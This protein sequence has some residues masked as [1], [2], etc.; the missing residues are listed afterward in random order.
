M[1]ENFNS[2]ANILFHQ[3]PFFLITLKS[4]H[5]DSITDAF[6][7]HHKNTSYDNSRPVDGVMICTPTFTHFD[8][9]RESA[10]LGLTIF[11]EKPV[12]ETGTKIE[13]LFEYCDSRGSKLCCS[14]QRR[15]DPSYIA[16]KMA[17]SGGA[18]G[19][20]LT[21][22]IF[23]GDNP[24]PPLEF[25]LSGGNIFMDLS[26]HDVDYIRWCLND[27]V[28]SVYATGTSSNEVLK[29]AGISDNATLLLNFRKGTVVTI[30]MSRSASYGYDQR[31]EI[32]GERG[33]LKV[34]D[35]TYL[36]LL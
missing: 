23:F 11:T 3:T 36:L 6:E 1:K 20:P 29:D 10:D 34:M 15:F 4:K 18:I 9:I 5:F 13:S 17:L 22:R 32:F 7:H 26:A 21:A 33:L 31:C 35:G 25:L 2:F 27:E 14:Y 30:F 12:D 28:E 19:K 8:L 24:C 16:T